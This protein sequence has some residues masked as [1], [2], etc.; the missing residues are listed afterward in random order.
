MLKVYHSNQL[1]ILKDIAV[2]LMKMAPL[3][4]ALAEEVILVQSPGMAQ[5]LQIEL[6]IHFG[7]A[8]NIRFP[9]P[10]SFIWELFVKILPDI[11]QESAFNKNA[12][13]WKLM[14]LIPARLEHPA[15]IQLHSYLQDDQERQKL[16]KLSRRIADLFDQ[17]LVYR[18]EWLNQWQQGQLADISSEHQAW[19]SILWQDLVIRTQQLGQPQWH[20][21][22]LYQLLITTLNESKQPPKGLPERVFICGISSLPP[23]Y[24]QS[25]QALG[26]H[27]DVHLLFTNPC[28]HYWGDIQ[29]RAFLD[30]MLNQK[31]N[32]FFSQQQTDWFKQPLGVSDW[33]SATGQ[34]QQVN[35]LLASLG[36]QG[37]DNLYLLSQMDSMDQA[38]DAFA[39]IDSSHLLGQLQRDILELED[40]SVIGL[41]AQQ[42]QSSRQRRTLRREDRSFSLHA[43]HSPQREIEVVQDYLLALMEQ[44]PELQP[45]DIIVMV[46]DIDAYSP[47]IQAVFAAAKGERYLPWAISDRRVSH[48]HPVIQAFLQLLALPVLRF[49]A[50]QV[51][52]LLEAPALAQRFSITEEGLILLRRWVEESGI[53]WGLDDYSLAELE[54]PV[55]HQ[56]TWQF[57][58][59]RMLLGYA[60]DSRTGDWQGILPYDEAGGLIGE[61][62][63]QLASLLQSLSQWREILRTARTLEQWLPYCRQLTESFF[64][65]DVESQAALE[66]IHEQWQK[67]LQPGIEAKLQDSISISVL[68]DE[69]SSMLDQQRISQRFLAG[70]V[71]FC[72][73]M[74]MRSIPFKVVCLLGMNE[75]VYPRSLSPSGFDL[76]QQ[77]PRKG[78][79]SRRDEDR[80]LLLEALISARDAFYISFIGRDIQD[81][82]PRL[83]S[84]L[85]SEMV[86]YVSLNFCLQGDEDLDLDSSADSLVRHLIVQHPAT[87]YAAENYHQHGEWQS[88]AG[89]W[90]PAARGQGMPEQPFIQP[91]SPVICSELSLQ[92][93]LSFWR[94]PIRGWFTQRLA[95]TFD[96]NQTELPQSE[97][98]ELDALQRYQFN[99]QLLNTL[100][101]QQ[102]ADAFLYQQQLAGRLPFGA[103]A[104]LFW[105]QQYQQ[106]S[107]IATEIIPRLGEQSSLEIDIRLQ[108]V[109][110]TGWI[111]QLQ[112]DGLLRWRPA[113]LNY[114]DGLLLFIEHLLCCASG[115]NIT[116]TMYGLENSRWCFKPVAADLALSQ[117][118]QLMQGYLQGMQSP[119]WLLKSSGGGW[120]QASLSKHSDP[121]QRVID[122]NED[123]QHKARQKLQDGWQDG[124]LQTG[125]GSDPYVRRLTRSLTE[126]QVRQICQA[127]EQWYLPVI[128][129]HDPEA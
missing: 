44:D 103:F 55:T 31:R 116:S 67:L 50:E 124:Y 66:I 89:E 15:F 61:L 26:R 111:T 30:R 129:A 54:L 58:L 24:L 23:I 108:G 65:G 120:L 33:F 101:R 86:E 37:R 102:D 113:K 57:G 76:M 119:L 53:R 39:D 63:G 14:D 17:Y 93:F 59:R 32:K 27:I 35:P 68:K 82:Q 16:F 112:S 62:A 34:Q 56:N 74:P 123:V 105:Q 85:V 72:T 12:M 96:H 60:M 43:C 79:R 20:R 40:H 110:L 125:E 6:A 52:A 4:D 69:L 47:Y 121:K 36:K 118:T 25:L 22:N 92:Q 18:P 38:I 11:P 94:A 91:L 21:A 48:A 13:S 84:V 90:L 71:N 10:A 88:F 107:Q 97:P 126:H 115:L 42:F 7:I 3:Q 128:K 122:W 80:Y 1:D 41:T 73:L 45:R 87:P 81:N 19:Q 64:C 77:Q 117:L 51:L 98:F 2:H 28:R 114:S 8:A 70:Q 5:W 104:T 9:L 29:D 99:Q 106:M 127:A 75:G 100:V 95:I 78:D 46:A 49:T 83:P 109:R